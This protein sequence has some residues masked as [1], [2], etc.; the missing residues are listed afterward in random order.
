MREAGVTNL[1][2]PGKAPP[3]DLAR[4]F[5]QASVHVLPSRSE[6]VPKVT[7]EALAC[8]LPAVIFGNYGAPN[9]TDGV[10]GFVVWSDEELVEKTGK[11]IDDPALRRDMGQAAAEM[12]ARLSWKVLGPQWE[13]AVLEHLS[14][15]C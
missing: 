4:A 3:E 8:G 12:A 1:A 15:I 14:G 9:V 11:L 5:R 13:K 6:G 2:F 10:N 7:Q